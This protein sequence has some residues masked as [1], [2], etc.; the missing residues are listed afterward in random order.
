MFHQ[1]FG[2]GKILSTDGGKL[3]IAFEK[4]GNK[5]VMASFVEAV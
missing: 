5:K 3:E 2:Y 4:A 1:K